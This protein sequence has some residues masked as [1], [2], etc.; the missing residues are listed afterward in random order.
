MN[1]IQRELHVFWIR[2]LV[3]SGGIFNNCEIEKKK[4]FCPWE[5]YVCV[6]YVYFVMLWK[7]YVCFFP[8][9]I[10]LLCVLGKSPESTNPSDHD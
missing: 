2:H 1:N 3:I 8:A 10:K 9:C 6:Y 7:Y 4:L 5:Y